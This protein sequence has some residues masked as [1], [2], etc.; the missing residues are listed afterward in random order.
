MFVLTRFYCSIYVLVIIYADLFKVVMV[1]N[2]GIIM[3]STYN[4]SYD[5]TSRERNAQIQVLHTL[6]I[7]ILE[8]V[9]EAG[10]NKSIDDICSLIK[11]VIE[12]LL[13]ASMS[14]EELIKCF[15]ETLLVVNNEMDSPQNGMK[16]LEQLKQAHSY[17]MNN[18]TMRDLRI[19]NASKIMA[20]LKLDFDLREFLDLSVY[21]GQEQKDFRNRVSQCFGELYEDLRDYLS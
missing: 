8:K 13:D 6:L 10:G 19:P 5:I 9:Q 18:T 17:Q 16:I 15:V 12:E 4:E 14:G 7:Q 3:D 20:D 21:D 11:P 2:C 1:S